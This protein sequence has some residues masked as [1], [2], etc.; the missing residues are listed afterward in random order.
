MVKLYI[1][2]V[3]VK[4]Y[5]LD[6]DNLEDLSDELSYPQSGYF[7]SPAYQ[8]GHWDGR[9]RLLKERDEIPTTYTGLMYLIR[10]YDYN[11]ENFGDNKLDDIEMRYYQ[12]DAINIFKKKKRGVISLPTGSGKSAVIVK[13][14]LDINV[15]TIIVVNR[16][17]L[18]E[19]MKSD[20]KQYT[21]LRDSEINI[22]G[23]G[24]K[25]YNEKN[26]I[27]VGTYQS[28]MQRKYDTI[29]RKAKMLVVD[30]C[31]HQRI[32]KI[33]EITEKAINAK[34]KLAVSAT[35]NREDKSDL[36][37]EGL[38]GRVIYGIPISQL[39]KDGYLMRPYIY[40]IPVETKCHP[41]LSYEKI[42]KY[43]SLSE[44]RNVAFAKC[45]VEFA[46]RGKIVLISILRLKQVD[47]LLKALKEVDDI[48]F[49]IKIITGCDSG[50]EKIRTIKKMNKG[51]YPIVISTLFGEGVNIPKL[52]CLINA[53]STKSK[54]DAIQQVGRTLRIA[55][56]KECP[57][58]I[59]AWDYNSEIKI[60]NDRLN[61]INQPIIEENRL[62]DEENAEKL[63]EDPECEDLK[64]H[65]KLEKK[66]TDY[67]QKYARKRMRVY[68]AEP[69]FVVRK[70]SSIQEIFDDK[71]AQ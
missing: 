32:N 10:H 9:V 51:V 8:S 12:S 54:I 31:H 4:I 7:F 30:E 6:E 43:I 52:D 64:K 40:F 41:L 45:A 67:F 49:D 15:P 53:R 44:E 18:L 11:N 47:G 26:F 29:I 1:D 60:H 17:A 20:I 37:L 66:K 2:C 3:F 48:G 27:T 14:V 62:I 22:I 33:G 5:G 69:E 57:I 35:P 61:I 36:A 71:R 70:V 39:I 55:E 23:G 24:H 56:D 58:C 13:L 34:Y 46:K 42:R 63:A 38:A 19:Q 21:G 65:K 68:N 28:L 50:E 25:H 16:N 59:D